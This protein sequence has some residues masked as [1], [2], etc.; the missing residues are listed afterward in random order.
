MFLRALR[1]VSPQYF[2]SEILK[3]FDIG[4]NLCYP[5]AFLDNCFNKA[6]KIFYQNRSDVSRENLTSNNLILP[7]FSEFSV[8]PRLLRKLDIQVIFK[9]ENTWSKFL[10]KNSPNNDCN[11]IYKIPC[12]DCGKYYIGETS[13]C[14]NFRVNQHKNYVKRFSENSAVFL[15]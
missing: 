8:L 13:K 10:I 2:D 5:E 1:V 14:I 11:I 3:I 9:Y 15:N 6:K 4:K 12:R 7:Y